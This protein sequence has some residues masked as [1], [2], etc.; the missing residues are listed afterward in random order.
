MRA[1]AVGIP[2]KG[3]ITVAAEDLRE[4]E[5]LA[6][7]LALPDEVRGDG[8][9]EVRVIDVSGRVLD[10][11]GHPVDGAGTGLRIE[12]DPGWLRPGRYMISVQT[13]D[14]HPLA[15]RRYV[16]EVAPSPAS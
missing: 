4:G 14:P 8:V 9:H 1:P 2:D 12:I 6:L 11:E 13:A 16:L 15:S 7:G 5:V 10:V 3:R